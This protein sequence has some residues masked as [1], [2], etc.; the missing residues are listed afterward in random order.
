MITSFT[1]YFN[2]VNNALSI[3]PQLN[4][5][6]SFTLNRTVLEQ[7]YGATLPDGVQTLHLQAID[8]YGNVSVKDFNFI[9]DT[10]APNTT[11][12][13]LTANSDSGISNNDKI[14]KISTPTITGIAEVGS[15]VQLYSSG[16]LIGSTTTNTSGNWQITT[17][18]LTDGVQN[19]TATVSDVAGNT[20]AVSTPLTINID[21]HAP[22]GASN[23]QLTNN[24][25]SGISNNDKITNITTPTIT[26]IAEAGTRVQLY[27]DGQLAG[28]TTANPD[29]TWLITTTSLTE[30]NHTLTAIVTDIAGNVSTASDPLNIVID[31]TAPLTPSGLKLTANTDTG[32]SNSDNITNNPTPTITGVGEAG[33]L[34]KLFKD[35]S[36]VGTTTVSSD[37]TWLIPIAQQL[38]DGLYQF[39]ALAKD[40]AGNTS[41]PSELL[42][43]TIDTTI[44]NPTNIDLIDISD[45]GFDATD[46]ITNISSPTLTGTAEPNSF[47]KLYNHDELIGETIAPDTGN[48]WLNTTPL[49]DG[50]YKFTVTTSDIAGN[51]SQEEQPF[52]L[53]IDKTSPVAPTHLKLTANTDTGTSNSDNITNNSTPTI[54]GLGE[55]GTLIKLFNSVE[56]VGET[57][58]KADGAWAITLNQLPDGT[59]NFIATS[60]DI[61]G[62][63]S[64]ASSVL[65]IT[66]DTAV[67]SPT[68]LSLLTDSGLVNNDLITNIS[69]PT[70]IGNSESG[71]LVQLFEGEQL[72]GET[73][74]TDTGSWTII[75]NNLTEGEHTLTAI[76][77]DIAGN[78]SAKS[79]PLV[80]VI[81]KTPP[82]PPIEIKL[83]ATTDSGISNS[84][85][86]TNNSAPTITGISEPGTLIQLF[87]N[88]QI[89]GSTTTNAEGIWE[90]NLSPLTDGT[91][92]FTAK[93][94]DI[95]GNISTTSNPITLII[96]T[97]KPETPTGL[98]LTPETDSGISN[99][100]NITNNQT[101]IITGTGE[102]GSLIQLFNNNQL[103]GN[104]TVN[105][106]GNWEISIETLNEGLYNF[107]ALATDTAGNVSQQATPVI[108]TIDTTAPDVANNLQVTPDTDTGISNSDRITNNL[109]PLLQEVPK[110]TQLYNYL[111]MGN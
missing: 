32:V 108:I 10:T 76:S 103:L 13:N 70:I 53:I 49:I 107:T 84:D 22:S 61:A 34:I 58:V 47:V 35:N 26:G 7:I 51:T 12:L 96:D 72:I 63:I 92:S 60:T 5:D 48:W 95:A 6:G 43:I 41:A 11:N 75:P 65:S 68:N 66:V 59:D 39:K 85:N 55:A 9:L 110:V 109:H 46:N 17:N 23:L 89:I 16:Q 37:G 24:S 105:P 99:N 81:D 19:L 28:S 69:A 78:I 93:G 74:A 94:I 104:A 44:V 27:S 42:T 38:T 97:T 82:L 52:N 40:T 102:A 77:T 98:K 15:L 71:T 1:A 54:T 30:G 8:L 36:L 83:T 57:I 64:T 88:N 50:I 20:S 62:N 106:D 18:T 29:K 111:I 67:T 21:T 100:D 3:R 90:I 86:I 4:S 73:T 87:N 31:T 79:Q 56:L 80:I 45:S 91:Y 14:T 2:N 25:D 33:S 101:K